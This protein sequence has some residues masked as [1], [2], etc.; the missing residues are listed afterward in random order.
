M[1]VLPLRQCRVLAIGF[2]IFLHFLN[3]HI[4]VDDQFTGGKDDYKR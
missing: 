3:I 1:G 2:E 4:Y